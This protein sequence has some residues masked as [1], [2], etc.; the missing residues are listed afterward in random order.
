MVLGISQG[1]LSIILVLGYGRKTISVINVN[2][3]IKKKNTS[4]D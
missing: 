1:Y 2:A 3:I 4:L